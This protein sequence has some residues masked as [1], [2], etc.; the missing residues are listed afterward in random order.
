MRAPAVLSPCQHLVPL[1]LKRFAWVCAWYLV[2]LSCISLMWCGWYGVLSV[3]LLWWM[4][5]N[6][7]FNW[8]FAFGQRILIIITWGTSKGINPTCHMERQGCGLFWLVEQGCWL[9]SL[10]VRGDMRGLHV[11]AVIL[12]V[13]SA[14]AQLAFWCSWLHHLFWVLLFGFVSAS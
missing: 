1:F 6:L 3:G 14:E 4:S 13:S 7:L 9:W 2:F 5:A 12:R 10:G 11:C 8:L